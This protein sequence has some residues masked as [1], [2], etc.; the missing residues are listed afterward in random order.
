MKELLER[1]T[2][3]LKLNQ[4]ESKNKQIIAEGNQFK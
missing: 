2:S 4:A 1:E 3:E